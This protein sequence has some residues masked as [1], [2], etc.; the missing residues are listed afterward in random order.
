[1]K[2]IFWMAGLVLCANAVFA[3]ELT[4]EQ[5]ARYRS[6]ITELRCL[7]CQN[8]TIAESN[9]PLAADLRNQVRAQIEAGKSDRDIHE[10]LTSRYGDFVLYRPPFKERTWLLWVGPFALLL[11]AAAAVALFIRRS[12]PPAAGPADPA[13][14]K[15]L[16][17][18]E[19]SQR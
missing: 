12:R 1:M 15:K 11:V 2:A 7:V 5:D 9:A 18:D 16:L 8:Q 10:Y 13:A 14:L 19:G 17:D 3:A 6:L 4:P